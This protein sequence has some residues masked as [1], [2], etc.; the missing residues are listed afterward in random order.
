MAE[1]V[2]LNKFRKAKQRAEAKAK[3]AENRA[4]S[5]RTKAQKKQDRDETK[6]AEEKLEGH[7]LDEPE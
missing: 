3:A 5:G 2:N 6:A 4:K 1:I 7:K